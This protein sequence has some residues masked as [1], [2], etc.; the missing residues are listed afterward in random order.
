MTNDLKK[1]LIQSALSK[2]KL[3]PLQNETLC[4]RVGLSLTNGYQIKC[5]GYLCISIEFKVGL[6]KI[7]HS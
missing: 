2:Q 6:I 7:Q 4:N 3:P 5:I 1:Y